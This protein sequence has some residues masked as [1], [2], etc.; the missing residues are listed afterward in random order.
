VHPT[1]FPAPPPRL[2]APE[3]YT[4]V[5][6]NKPCSVT[7]TATLLGHRTPA[8]TSCPGVGSLGIGWLFASPTGQSRSFMLHSY[9][10]PYPQACSHT[11][12]TA[13]MEAAGLKLVVGANRLKFQLKPA[14]KAGADLSE[15]PVPVVAAQVQAELVQT[16]PGIVEVPP[17]PELSRAPKPEPELVQTPSRASWRCHPRIAAPAA[18]TT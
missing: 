10:S 8:H 11:Q 3:A 7:L 6:R 13:R 1:I 14:D 17:P 18:H 2:P 9:C 12:A 5:T 4:Q 16:F 15:L